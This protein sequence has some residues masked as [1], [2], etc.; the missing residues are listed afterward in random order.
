[1][2]VCSLYGAGFYYIPGTDACIKI[3]GF[4]RT[5]WMYNAGG[6]LT[7]FTSGAN[8]LF[9]RGG[10]VITSRS[11][12]VVTFDAREQTGYG[13]LRAYI[14]GGW[15]YTSNDGPTVSLPGASVPAAGGAAVAGGAPNINGNTYLLR[16]FIQWGGFTLGKT[17]SFFDFYNTAKYSYQ[18]NFLFQ[19][20]EGVG[21]NTWAYTQMLGNGVAASIAVQDNT[22][23][24]HPVKDLNATPVAGTIPGF[25]TTFP[26]LASGGPTNG[27]WDNT[28]NQVPDI[29]GN[30]RVDQAWG[31][32]Q[33]AGV[34]HDNRARFYGATANGLIAGVAHPADKW[35]WAASA[36][37]EINL[38]FWAKG[39]SFA[40]QTQ[41][42]SGAS[43]NCYLNSGARQ[44][45]LSWG[46]VNHGSR[47]GLGWLDDAY[48]ANTPA[49]GATALQL[50]TVWNVFAGIQHYWTPGLRTSLYAG[51][52][53]YT[54]NSSAV[55]ALVCQANGLAHGCADW[56]AWQIGSRTIWNPVRNLDI[57]VEALYSELSKSAFSGAT[58]AFAPPGAATG[59]YSVGSA[60]VV[61][62]IVRAQ[63]NFYP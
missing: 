10:D 13:T 3:G 18:T 23:F 45:D 22:Q 24:A 12:A 46:L 30:L 1:V 4:L 43:E 33:I 15:Q 20:Y 27:P 25:G 62:G 48:L 47:I 38:P 52:A 50:P 32:A 57:G 59:V 9:S 40:V 58:I 17:A 37:I 14:A 29:V 53:N 56:A 5:E 19:D 41:Y 16:A 39:D 31:S 28:G 63:Y 44:A 35:G 51:Y 7:T 42:C 60:H 21:V 54:A 61:S 49:T 11:R 34:L 26:I 6:S 8:A 36:G 55:D 2:K